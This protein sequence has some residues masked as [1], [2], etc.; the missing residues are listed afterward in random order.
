MH[1]DR[2]DRIGRGLGRRE[3]MAIILERDG[4]E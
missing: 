4:A 2:S 3:R 1:E